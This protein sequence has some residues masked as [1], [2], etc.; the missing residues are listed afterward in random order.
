VDEFIEIDQSLFGR[1]V[2]NMANGPLEDNLAIPTRIENLAIDPDCIT[3]LVQ[4]PEA[5]G[6]GNQGLAVSWLDL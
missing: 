1:T 3:E 5:I 6:L 2:L 4:C